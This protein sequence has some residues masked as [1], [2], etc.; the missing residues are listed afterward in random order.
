[1]IT[2]WL[3]PS[4]GASAGA[5]AGCVLT[6]G[7][8]LGAGVLALRPARLELAGASPADGLSL[9]F[10]LTILGSRRLWYEAPTTLHTSTSPAEGKR[11]QHDCQIRGTAANYV[12]TSAIHHGG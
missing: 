7:A 5:A 3:T 6:P 12:T 4:W 10:A 8:A 1:M 11:T 9:G 2:G